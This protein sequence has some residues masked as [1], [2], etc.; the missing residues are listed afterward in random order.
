MVQ[1]VWWCVRMGA[2]Q[3]KLELPERYAVPQ[4]VLRTGLMMLSDAQ[5]LMRRLQE[6]ADAS[7]RRR[8]RATCMHPVAPPYHP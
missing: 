4:C 2:T 5:P 7:A 6:Q 8:L 3:T 1:G